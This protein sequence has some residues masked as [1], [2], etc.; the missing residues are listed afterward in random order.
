MFLTW[1]GSKRQFHSHFHGIKTKLSD[2]PI[3]LSIGKTI[4]YLDVEILQN[5]GILRTKVYIGFCR[6]LCS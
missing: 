2:L 1:N 6:S 3:E 4:H 5:N